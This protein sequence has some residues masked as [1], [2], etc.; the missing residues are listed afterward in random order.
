MPPMKT[1]LVILNDLPFGLTLILMLRFRH[2][3]YGRVL[4]I[5]T[6]R[7]TLFDAINYKL[8]MSKEVPMTLQERAYTS[9]LANI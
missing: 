3:I 5:P 8:K 9:P 1:A 2:S 7:W 6:P 4:E